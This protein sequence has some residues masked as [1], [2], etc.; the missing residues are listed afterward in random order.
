MALKCIASLVFL[1]VL[2]GCVQRSGNKNPIGGSHV[3]TLCVVEEGA[4]EIEVI[5]NPAT[6]PVQ[7]NPAEAA[8]I[9][10]IFADA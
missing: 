10:D 3:G 9:P 6:A 8:R 4:P 1:L 5:S 7:V 2:A